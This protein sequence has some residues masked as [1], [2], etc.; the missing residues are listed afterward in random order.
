MKRHGLRYTK[1]YGVWVMIKQR[2][3]NKSNKDYHN[4]WARGITVC[5]AWLNVQ[6]FYSWAIEEKD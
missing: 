5:N 6:N 1:L 3:F 4:Y 2:C